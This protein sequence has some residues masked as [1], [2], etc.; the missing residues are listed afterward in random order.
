M[1]KQ[2][3]LHKHIK[4]IMTDKA[5]EEQKVM[6]WFEKM[7]GDNPEVPAI[8][9]EEKGFFASDYLH[10]G[11]KNPELVYEFFDSLLDH[12][13]EVRKTALELNKYNRKIRRVVDQAK[14][15]FKKLEKYRVETS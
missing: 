9:L 1:P 4:S 5:V 14:K 6:R 12:Q 15:K 11:S 13:K 8:R 7:F 2:T 10:C 3:W